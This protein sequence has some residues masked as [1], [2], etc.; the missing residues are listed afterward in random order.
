MSHD[1]TFFFFNYF[2][3]RDFFFFNINLWKCETQSQPLEAGDLNPV[4]GHCTGGQLS[5]CFAVRGDLRAPYLPM[6]SI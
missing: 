4:Q 2:L 3:M 6:K 5:A 1:F